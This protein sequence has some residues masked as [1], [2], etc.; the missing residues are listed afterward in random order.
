VSP[1]AILFDFGGTLDSDGVPWKERFYRLWCEEAGEV[2]RTEFDP[3]FYAADDA[4]VGSLDPAS[5]LTETVA[6]LARGV[7]HR[8]AASRDAADRVA[9]RFS[10][11]ALETLA[12]RA[13]MLARLARR[14][15]LGVVSNFYGNL[16]GVC[17]EAG[18]ASSFAALVDS[19]DVGCTKPEPAIFRAALAKVGAAP[20]EAVFVG[21][22]VERD[23]AGARALGMP[24]VLV[25]ADGADPFLC[26]PGDRF[27]RRLEELEELLA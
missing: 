25:R 6:R 23:M 15:R 13:P 26:C 14:Y 24:H 27:V 3:A 16:A 2:P 7:A 11:D 19:C 1:R 18:L 21:D 12:R 20:E 8:L 10:A 17:E 22:S 9:L 5:T 4:L